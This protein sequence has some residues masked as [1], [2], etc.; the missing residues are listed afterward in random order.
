MAPHIQG[1]VFH[2]LCI[3]KGIFSHSLYNQ[4]YVFH[5]P[6]IIKGQGSETYPAQ[7]RQSL[8]RVPPPRDWGQVGIQ[9]LTGIGQ[10]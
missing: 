8:D 7:G 1:Y 6:C 3:I 9:W 4:G 2:G 5:D 10:R